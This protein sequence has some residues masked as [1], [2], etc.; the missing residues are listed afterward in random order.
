MDSL[1]SKTMINISFF[2]GCFRQKIYQNYI[3]WDGL[4]TIT[5]TSEGAASMALIHE[6]SARQHLLLWYC[7]LH[8][9]WERQMNGLH[10]SL[11]TDV[12]LLLLLSLATWLPACIFCKFDQLLWLV[13][14]WDSWWSLSYFPNEWIWHEVE[15]ETEK[16]NSKTFSLASGWKKILHKEVICL[17]AMKTLKWMRKLVTQLFHVLSL[18]RGF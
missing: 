12:T 1:F 7:V 6:S 15:I 11:C 17:T 2:S 5:W 8:H 14:V 4:S 3:A 16:V 18:E 9:V 13:N 10:A